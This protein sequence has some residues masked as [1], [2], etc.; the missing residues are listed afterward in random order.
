M[1]QFLLRHFVKDWQNTA[2]AAV[3]TRYGRMAGVVGIICNLLLALAKLVAGLLA[4]SIAVM[5]DAVNN[6][7]DLSSSVITLIGFRLAAKPADR[8][9]P[10]GHA[11]VEYIAGM[12]VALLVMVVG[13][14]L[15]KSGIERI[16]DPKPVAFTI[17]TLCVLAAS[18]LLK[19]W[20]AVFNRD[21]GRRIS[22]SALSATFVDS[23]ND[24]IATLAVLVAAV[25]SRVSDLNLDGWMATGVAVFILIS[26]IGLVKDTLNPLLGAAPDPTLVQRLAERIEGYAGVI[27]THDL[28]VHDYGPARRFASAHVEVASSMDAVAGHELIDRIERDV[29]AE[30]GIHLI[31]HYDPVDMTSSEEGRAREAASRVVADV[32]GRLTIHEFHLQDGGCAFDVLAPA[33]LEMSDDELTEKIRAGLAAAGFAFQPQI[34]IDRSFAPIPE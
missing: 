13:V 32:D 4:G 15:L 1:T 25:V 10:F 14:E 34:K 11:R 21:L 26:G 30:T 9:H 18:V 22:S 7:S 23:R 31:I 27:G 2:D 17:P 33:A 28:I 29:L 20:M 12:A 8:E 5:A 16:A 6:L 24:A 3:R 19:M